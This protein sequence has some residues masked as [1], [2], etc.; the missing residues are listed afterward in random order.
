[1]GRSAQIADDPRT[2]LPNKRPIQA[3]RVDR[4][5]H[6][7]RARRY[8]RFVSADELVHGPP[9]KTTPP[10]HGRPD[11]P[12]ISGQ[13]DRPPTSAARRAAVE[14]TAGALTGV[15]A[16]GELTSLREDWAA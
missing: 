1:M 16:P 8:A 7:S 2:R 9:E 15:Y 10:A 6:R 11:E 13:G 4:S 14:Q 5:G 3:A 12:E